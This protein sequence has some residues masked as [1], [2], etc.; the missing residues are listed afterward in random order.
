M[1]R[2]SKY[3]HG[4]NQEEQERLDVQANFLERMIHEQLDM[5]GVK[6][7]LEVG[8]GVGAQT[9]LMLQK[10]PDMCIHGIDISAEQIQK[11]AENL[12]KVA[13]FQGRYSLEQADAASFQMPE[14]IAADGAFICW[15]LEHLAEPLRVLQN[16]KKVLRPGSPIFVTEVY[17]QSQFL[18]PDSPAIMAY[19]N[20]FNQMQSDF[21]GH[22]YIGAQLGGLL[23]EAGFSNIHVYPI[24]QHHDKRNPANRQQMMVY[25]K[26]LLMSAAEQL[27]E[28]RYIKQ[29]D[30][31]VV[32]QEIRQ[33]M[34]HPDA[35]YFYS[36]FQ[37]VAKS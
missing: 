24:Y 7:L 25:F 32:Q 13:A 18:Y 29:S 34:D 26:D 4:Q 30:L 19:W 15:V 22:P 27:I 21:G 28:H 33:F 20:A 6:Q 9:R 8:V 11:A 31:A 35:V 5:S 12:S 1:G 2:A 16:C 17:N 14:E 36:G 3:I 37:A 10:Y 23:H